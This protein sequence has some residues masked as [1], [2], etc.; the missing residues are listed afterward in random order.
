METFRTTCPTCGEIDHSIDYYAHD[1]FSFEDNCED[2]GARLPNADKD[3]L[4]AVA[5]HMGGL[6]D[7]AMNHFEK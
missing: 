6:V 1:E 7:D 5:D 4:D 3:V 2:C